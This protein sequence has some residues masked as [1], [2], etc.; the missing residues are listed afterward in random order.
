MAKIK[1]S[2]KKAETVNGGREFTTDDDLTIQELNA[3]VNNSYYGVDFAE[4][5]ADTPIVEDTDPTASPTIEVVN[6]PKTVNGEEIVYKKFK[7]KNFKGKQGVGISSIAFIGT[8]SNGGNI[9][10]I[11]LDDSRT[12]QFTA[13]AGG[14]DTSELESN[15]KL[16]LAD[17]NGTLL[18]GNSTTRPAK[19]TAIGGGATL[20]GGNINATAIGNGSRA[21]AYGTAVGALSDAPSNGAVA[22]GGGAISDDDRSVA[23]GAWANATASKAIQIGQG[24]NEIKNT[25]QFFGD[26]VY[27]HSTH[28]FNA[29]TIL[30]DG[31][32]V[33]NAE[34][35]KGG[36]SIVVEELE[37]ATLYS[38]VKE[39][40]TSNKLL[41]L[42]LTVHETQITISN[43]HEYTIK[44]ANTVSYKSS[45][46][47]IF[48]GDIYLHLE[49]CMGSGDIIFTGKLGNKT[50]CD[51]K[52]D[53][54]NNGTI[55]Y[56]QTIINN[57]NLV[58]RGATLTSVDPSNPYYTIKAVY[59]D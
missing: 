41:Y 49:V 38:R 57:T 8:D 50:S 20:L 32:P 17:K 22:I 23:V 55:E 30:Q 42:V 18:I 35:V 46:V 13:P 44:S 48:S 14:S 54:S 12:Y 34:D 11:T 21:G 9:Y 7:F 33:A 16:I 28:T 24:T 27:D 59:I 1:W 39:L 25:V 43:S 6:N 36:S 47:S 29:K 19:S 45:S 2:R 15:T 3:M 51:Y 58:I 56:N 5:M 37:K 4:A 31:K 26:N 53:T 10:E 52:I 40:A